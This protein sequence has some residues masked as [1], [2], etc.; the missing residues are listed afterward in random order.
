MQSLKLCFFYLFTLFLCSVGA[1]ASGARSPF[2]LP[3]PFISSRV[4]LPESFSA[5]ARKALR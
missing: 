5:T 2:Y 4:R 3:L 1:Q